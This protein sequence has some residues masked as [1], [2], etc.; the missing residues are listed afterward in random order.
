MSAQVP[1]H[2]Y[3]AVALVQYEHNLPDERLRLPQHMGNR[4]SVV[5]PF[6]DD[7][8]TNSASEFS[9]IR[10]MVSCVG[11][12]PVGR[13][14]ALKHLSPGAHGALQIPSIQ[15]QVNAIEYVFR[16]DLVGLARL[17]DLG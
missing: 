10:H 12:E 5:R 3:K 14:L 1:R 11:I 15:E 4:V 13:E 6:I 17:A 2:S 7:A 16:R 8:Q 9:I